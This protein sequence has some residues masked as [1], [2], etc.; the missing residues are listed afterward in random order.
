MKN[1]LTLKDVSRISG[2]TVGTLRLYRWAGRLPAPR[3][4]LGSAGLYHPRDIARFM[5]TRERKAANR[6]KGRRGV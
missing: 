4:R 5:A 1:F 2:L 6:A 3:K